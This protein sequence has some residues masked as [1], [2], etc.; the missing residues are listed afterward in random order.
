MT[1]W[2]A[3]LRTRETGW[4]VL[5]R[6]LVGLVVFFPEGLEFCFSRISSVPVVSPELAFPTLT[7][8]GLS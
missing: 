8:W 5:I 4:V 6:L 7:S 1:L 3:L 2:R